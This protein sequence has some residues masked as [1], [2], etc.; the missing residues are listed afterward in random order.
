MDNVT[1]I[2]LDI[3]KSV[4]QLHGVDVVG[5]V[6]IRRKL[7][8]GWRG[9]SLVIERERMGRMGKESFAVKLTPCWAKAMS[10]RWQPWVPE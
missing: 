9:H 5:E 6:V 4:F 7:T 8:R 3:A 2:A 1:T 10:R